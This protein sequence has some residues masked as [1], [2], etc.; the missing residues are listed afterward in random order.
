MRSLY[1]L[2]SFYV[3]GKVLAVSDK[4]KLTVLNCFGGHICVRKTLTFC[5]LIQQCNALQI[6]I[7]APAVETGAVVTPC[8]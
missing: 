6:V 5:N 7:Q 1:L 3:S 8:Q 4:L 2:K